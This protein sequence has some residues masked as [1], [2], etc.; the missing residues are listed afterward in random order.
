MRFAKKRLLEMR[1][2]TYT[3]L[4][5]CILI[6][7]VIVIGYVLYINEG[8]NRCRDSLTRISRDKET[9]RM[10]SLSLEKQITDKCYEITR[11]I[12][13]AK[14]LN[15]TIKDQKSTIILLRDKINSLNIQLSHNK[16]ILSATEKELGV[17]TQKYEYAQPFQERVEQGMYR[18]K[19]YK[20][21]GDYDNPTKR[22][23][24]QITSTYPTTDNTEIWKRAK[25]VY[26]WIG[27]NYKYCG[28]K[29]MEVDNHLYIF[30]YWSPD[31]MLAERNHMCGDCDDHA[32]LFAGMLYAA[33]VPHNRVYVVCGDTPAGGHC[34]NWLVINNYAYTIDPVCANTKELIN[35]LGLKWSVQGATFPESEFTNVGCFSSYTVRSKMNPEGYWTV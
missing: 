6:I 18:S 13:E 33:G 20:L 7:L 25:R 35:F 5:I 29:G 3:G 23:V 8:M 1:K 4:G 12:T 11:L 21:L 34:W 9:L 27:E 17:T 32:F 14:N 2:R 30:Q 15:R 22:T 28:D 19:S 10:Q 26:E 24:S 31:E 16:E